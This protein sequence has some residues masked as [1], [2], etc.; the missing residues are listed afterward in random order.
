MVT[1]PRDVV[2]KK[3]RGVIALA[4]LGIGGSGALLA[5]SLSRE[6]A[7]NDAAQRPSA[8]A[9][10]T[11]DAATETAGTADAA[12]EA[13]ATPDAVV[14]HVVTPDAVVEDFVSRDADRVPAPV[15]GKRPDDKPRRDDKPRTKKTN[16]TPK[17]PDKAD[18][19]TP[20]DV[21]PGQLSIDA[22]PYATVYIDGK[23]LGDTPI[24][25]RSV[26]PGKHKLRLVD[27]T[28][29]ERTWDIEI[30]PGELTNRGPVN[31]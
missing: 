24:I 2:R 10:A 21:R 31:W 4:V 9:A 15:V 18:G 27:K 11:A 26:A 14:E 30:R 1:M 12:V 5:V 16:A 13:G 23:K 28:G 3:R 17:L 20:A 22:S 7:R 29:R 19:N 25:R 6:S 8:V